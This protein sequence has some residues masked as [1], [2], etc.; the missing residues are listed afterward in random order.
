MHLVPRVCS[1][2]DIYSILEMS[3]A[4]YISPTLVQ[5]C[6]TASIGREVWGENV[7]EYLVRTSS[8]L[9]NPLPVNLEAELAHSWIPP[10]VGILWIVL[11]SC[12]PRHFDSLVI[13]AS[14]FRLCDRSGDLIP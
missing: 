12:L 11:K 7:G 9:W 5:S 14:L 1:V 4:D 3:F 2:L 6:T 13:P 8:H 10:L